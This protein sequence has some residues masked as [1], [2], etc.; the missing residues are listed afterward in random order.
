MS[1][2]DHILVVDDERSMRDFLEIFFKKEG[3]SVSTAVGVDQAI[4]SLENLEID[5]VITDM[6]MPDRD[7]LDMLRAVNEHSPQ[8]TVI[9][10][11]AYASA[12]SAIA[13]MKEGAYDYITKPFKLDEIRLVVE[14]ALEKKQLSQENARL[15]SELRSH[16]GHRTIIGK[17][18][19][20]QEVFDLID[21]VAK[22][23]ASVL[24]SGESGTGK[25]LVA[26]ALHDQS[27]RC[28]QPFVALNCGAIPENLLESELFGHIRGS[29]TG[30]IGDKEGLFEVARGGTLFLDEVGELPLSLQVKLLRVIQEKSLRRVGGTKDVD[31]DVR[32]V[33]AT[34]RELE[35]LISEGSFRNDLFYRLNVIQIP[36]PPLRERRED[37]PLLIRHFVDKLSMESGRVV[38]SM[39]GEAL[40]RLIAYDYPGNVREL[41]NIVERSVALSRG[42]EIQVEMLPP[43]VLGRRSLSTPPL[44]PP[45]GVK[46]E[47]LLG[48]YERTL[49]AEALRLSGGV[50][51]QASRL[52]GVSFRSFR[53]RLEKLGI[54]DERGGVGS[55]V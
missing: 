42:E 23:R 17:S 54:D 20:I 40:K 28:D 19:V 45:S 9:V 8:T 22:T 55:A 46:L 14:K 38:E 7:G 37:I 27:D 36:I 48:D 34:N 18:R 21:Q 51:K 47:E 13:A 31:V 5:L 35:Q 52:L 2:S 49:L 41:E 3:F 44:I 50:K 15:K 25:E 39:S 24:I 16:A 1:T 11:T 30:A 33:S 4:L 12:E 26:R 10:M 53:Y 32:V 6:Q 43:S 29:F